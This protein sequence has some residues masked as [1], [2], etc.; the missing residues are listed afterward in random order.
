MSVPHRGL[1]RTTPRVVLAAMVA[2]LLVAS[3]VA[4][5][6][7]GSLDGEDHPFVGLMVAQDDE[8]NPLWRCSGTLI[9]STL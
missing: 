7:S 4:A 1:L 9:S 3:P 8:G 5:I 2:T 6:T